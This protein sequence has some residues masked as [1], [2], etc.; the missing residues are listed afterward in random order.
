MSSGAVE[1]PAAFVVMIRKTV[2][3]YPIIDHATRWRSSEH[4]NVKL[5]PSKLLL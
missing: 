2:T 5:L 1:K 3:N 4:S